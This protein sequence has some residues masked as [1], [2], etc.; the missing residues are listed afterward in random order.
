MSNSRDESLEYHLRDGAWLRRFVATLVPAQDV[1]D[2]VQSTW[3]AAWRDLQVVRNMRQWLRG[4]AA[5]LARM[6]HRRE[7]RRT[8]ALPRLQQNEAGPAIDEVVGELEVQRLVSEALLELPEPTRTIVVLRYQHEW[9]PAAI[10]EQVGLTPEAVRQR[11]H[12]GRECVRERLRRH[13][14]DDWR[15]CLV[16]LVPG[17]LHR[18][19]AASVGLTM[20][21]LS[22]ASLVLLAST[23]AFSATGAGT[24]DLATIAPREVTTMVATADRAGDATRLAAA[25]STEERIAAALPQDPRPQPATKP[26]PLRGRFVAAED[27]TPL[28]G[29]VSFSGS[30]PTLRGTI[31]TAADGTFVIDDP[32]PGAM[33]IFHAEGRCQRWHTIERAGKREL[34]DIPMLLGYRVRGVVVDDRGLPVP[35]ILIAFPFDGEFPNHGRISSSCRTANDGTFTA[36]GLLPEGAVEPSSESPGFEL[37]DAQ[38]DVLPREQPTFVTLVA[39][40][41]PGIRG[42]CFDSGGAPVAGVDLRALE[43]S[44]HP[45]ASFLDCGSCRSEADG[46]F[47]LFRRRGDS[48][49]VSID[50]G[51]FAAHEVNA[52]S[53]PVAWGTSGL[54]LVVAPRV[55]LL[56]QLVE[57][58]TTNPV[59]ARAVLARKMGL[60]EVST[61]QEMPAGRLTEQGLAAG[62]RLEIWPDDP[63]LLPVD[64]EVDESLRGR[65]EVRIEAERLRPFALELTNA[66]GVPVQAECDVLLRCGATEGAPVT[67][68]RI[69]QRVHGGASPRRIAKCTTDRD[70][71]ATLHAPLGPHDLV[72]AVN[73]ASGVKWLPVQLPSGSAA[74]RLTLP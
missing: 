9:S 48:A 67:D 61:V 7:V 51:V 25:G 59:A 33:C 46:S 66:A 21:V 45:L 70:G 26:I 34:G 6:R 3:L 27:G 14:G 5:N 72:L 22:M 39:A 56:V 41:L 40:R 30:G 43:T 57:Q 54:R 2:V 32:A 68:G 13:F 19:F 10:G 64:L 47:E 23:L 58:G 37:V 53:P 8:R 24:P 49:T 71:K 63:L 74:L 12:R 38:V 73:T 60:A 11:L 16:V 29:K 28:V 36:T 35:K 62:T 17:W 4:T 18:P 50:S 20:T 55:P 65:A 31:A 44:D 69:G 1:D 52:S 42:V 15:G